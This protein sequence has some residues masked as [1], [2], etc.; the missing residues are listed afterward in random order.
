MAEPKD[1]KEPKP[2]WWWIVVAIV[3]L[4]IVSGAVV[5]IWPGSTSSAKPQTAQTTQI[6]ASQSSTPP[7]ESDQKLVAAV[8]QVS[9]ELKGLRVDLKATQ[10]QSSRPSPAKVE[11]PWWTRTR[12]TCLDHMIYGLGVDPGTACD[13]LPQ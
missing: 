12:Q 13:G 1:E 6:K 8:G 10:K 3:A 11:K 2:V 5:L 7:A 9:E 4:L